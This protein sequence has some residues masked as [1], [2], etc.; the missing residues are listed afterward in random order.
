[1]FTAQVGL[2]PKLFSRVLRFQ[3]AQEVVSQASRPNWSEVALAGGYYDQSHLIHDFQEFS[4]LCPTDLFRRK[5]K[6]LL[7]NPGSDHKTSR[8]PRNHIAVIG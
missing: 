5:S 3:H 8:L 6:E 4:G 2:R 7:P 1:M